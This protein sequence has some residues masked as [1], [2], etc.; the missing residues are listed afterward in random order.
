MKLTGVTGD[1]EYFKF[2]ESDEI[3][4][5]KIHDVLTGKLAGCMF[6]G[7]IPKSDCREIASN[8]WKNIALK[9]RTDG[10]PG[11][12]VG[13]YHYKKLLSTYLSE[14][15]QAKTEIPKIFEG[16]ESPFE[17]I[18]SGLSGHLAHENESLVVRP[19]RHNGVEAC[20]YFMRA[21]K[22]VGKYALEPHDDSSQCTALNQLG[23]EI[24]NALNYEV[25][26]INM[27][28][29]NEGL[30]KLHYWDIQPDQS[31]KMKLNLEEVGYPYKVEDLQS[32]EL[33]E[34]DV[35]PGDV[36]FF[37]GKNVHAVS[38]PMGNDSYRTTIAGL[39][40]YIDESTIVYWT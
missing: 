16:V 13:T 10:V 4:I 11:A 39:M 34:L 5:E 12:Y 28:I 26:A 38:S 2:Y 21:W 24:Q 22:G 19:A 29:E 35:G 23:F 15:L 25:V 20:H 6:R 27:C 37:N 17:K 3:N 40:G 36:Y 9:S 32:F 8:F 31:S 30:S 14:S 18:M 33:I 7:V 1:R